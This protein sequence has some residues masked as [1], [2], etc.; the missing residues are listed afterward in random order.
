MVNNGKP[1]HIIPVG[2]FNCPDID[3]NN[4]TINPKAAEKE[5]Q[6]KLIDLSTE[7]FL[8][9]ISHSVTDSGC[10]IDTSSECTAINTPPPSVPLS[11]LYTLKFSGKISAD[12]IADSVYAP[13]QHQ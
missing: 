10:S 3:W 1:K 5:V 12:L 6:K 2:D 13:P 7:F 8:Y 11:F 4:M 9:S